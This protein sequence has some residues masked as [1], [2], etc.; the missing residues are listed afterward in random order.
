MKKK[1]NSTY[2]IVFFSNWIRCPERRLKSPKWEVKQFTICKK[3]VILHQILT[4]D[5]TCFW[6]KYF[7]TNSLIYLKLRRIYK[8]IENCW[9]KKLNEGDWKNVCDK[10][11]CMHILHKE[12]K[13]VYEHL[14]NE[15]RLFSHFSL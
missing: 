5:W 9:I 15:N 1:C 10:A 12:W 13:I 7:S 2:Q 14:R 4:F 6:I 3:W 8:G 11:I